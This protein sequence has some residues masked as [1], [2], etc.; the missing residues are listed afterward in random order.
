MVRTLSALERVREAL[1]PDWSGY[2][3]SH[4]SGP[5]GLE[6]LIE[7][8]HD[9]RSPL[10]SI[11]FLAETLQRGQSGTVNEL[12][13]RQ[14]GL[15]YSAALGLSSLASDAL[16]LAR[17]SNELLNDGLSPFSLTALLDSV[18]DI[19]RPMAEEKG[20]EVRL[21]SQ[22]PDSRLGNPLALGRVLLNLTSN[23]LKFTDQGFVEIR[24]AP[25]GPTRLEVSVR[26]SGRGINP[27]ALST[28]YEP[29]RRASGRSGYCFSGTGLG[30]TICRKL[31]AAMGSVLEVETRPQWGTRFYFELDLP[32]APGI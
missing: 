31:V 20:L 29:L 10:T 11:L 5:N 14:L 23:A 8:A 3:T 25:R 9:L 4:L 28:L 19:V 7:V 27:G 13:H 22:E 17:N 26:D 15:I 12:Q 18:R 32:P 6:V 1:E 30:L 16:E 24:T 21:V 2:L